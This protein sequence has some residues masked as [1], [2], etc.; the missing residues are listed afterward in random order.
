VHSRREKAVQ[1]ISSFN[2]AIIALS[3]G[4][5]SALVARLAKEH[6]AGRI[7]AVSATGSFHDSQE[8]KEA[9]ETARLLGLEHRFIQGPGVSDKGLR[10]NPPDRCYICKR[11]FYSTLVEMEEKEGLEAVM[12]GT[13]VD[14]D[15]PDRP[16]LRAGRELGIVSP[17]LESGISKNEVRKWAAELGLPNAAKPSNTC[18]AT[19]FPY[20]TLLSE[21][22]LESVAGAER[23]LKS[24]IS[25]NLRMRVHGDICRLE[26]DVEKIKLLD[27]LEKRRRV[28]RIL[29]ESGFR[30]VTL[31]LEGYRSGS[32]DDSGIKSAKRD[33][34]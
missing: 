7:I 19:R 21:K 32:M 17:L 2:S 9:G 13:N 26:M 31:D 20:N 4:V 22:V 12:D 27:D 8:L 15:R 30:Y 29:K 23:K 3:G 5:D 25:G 34:A 10:N 33:N 28:L 14:D 1:R 6:V 18:L 16:G 24:V 11:I